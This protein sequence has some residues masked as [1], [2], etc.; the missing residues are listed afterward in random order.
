MSSKQQFRLAPSSWSSQT[1]AFTMQWRIHWLRRSDPR[2]SF[3][4][5]HFSFCNGHRLCPHI[6]FASVFNISRTLLP[7][8]VTLYL[9]WPPCSLERVVTQNPPLLSAHH[10]PCISACDFC[11]APMWFHIWFSICLGWSWL[12]LCT[13]LEVLAC[14]LEGLFVCPRRT[15]YA[16]LEGLVCALEGYVY[17]LGGFFACSWGTLCVLLGNEILSYSSPCT[18]CRWLMTLIFKPGVNLASLTASW[19]KIWQVQLVFTGPVH[20]LEI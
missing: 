19:V 16:F 12:S 20:G 10:V 13:L 4:G 9:P 8:D 15:L 17:A 18:S 2:P 6:V 11:C 3:L 1:L 14:A 5:G 7:M